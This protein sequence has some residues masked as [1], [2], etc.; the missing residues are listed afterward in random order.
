MV[1]FFLLGSAVTAWLGSLLS[2]QKRLDF[3]PKT[4]AD[5]FEAERTEPC[6]ASCNFILRVREI[7]VASVSG[8]N[9]EGILTDIGVTFHRYV[10]GSG[11][12]VV[13][14]LEPVSNGPNAHLL[15]LRA[16][17]FSNTSRSSL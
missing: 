10:D 6:A 5:L 2:R 15:L 13:A 12:A 3:K 7:V 16:V 17:S 14:H 1:L 11:L 9:Q 8:K 4:D